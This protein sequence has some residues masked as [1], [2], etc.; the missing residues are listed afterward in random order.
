LRRYF[1]VPSPGRKKAQGP[2]VREIVLCFVVEADVEPNDITN[3]FD[4]DMPDWMVGYDTVSVSRQR[5]ATRA[6]SESM[7]WGTDT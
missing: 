5:R 2:K 1:G 4:D 3:L 6:E 7:C